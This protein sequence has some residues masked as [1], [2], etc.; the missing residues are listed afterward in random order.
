MICTMHY[1]EHSQ[2]VRANAIVLALF[3]MAKPF[4]TYDEQIEILK[5]RGLV[6]DDETSAKKFL[7]VDNYYSVING[8]KEPF[9]IS[10]SENYIPGAKFEY[11]KSL[12]LFDKELRHAILSTLLNIETMLKSIISY[13]IAKAY[14]ERSYLD[15]N[16]YNVYESKSKEKA[17]ELINALK[18]Q[19][20]ICET[21]PDISNENIRHYQANHGYVPIWV[22]CSHLKLGDVSKLYA[23]QK[24]QLKIAICKH[25]TSIYNKPITPNELYVF[26]RI[27]TNIRNLCAHNLRIYNYKTVYE[28]SQ[29]NSLMQK[30]QQN[31][32]T[33]LKYNNILSIVIIIY[34]LCDK[35]EFQRFIEGFLHELV[36]LIEL[37]SKFAVSLSQRQ[38]YSLYT[39]VDIIG[40]L[41]ETNDTKKAPASST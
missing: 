7:E 41:L 11:I 21:N 31:Y 4:K 22:L 5:S 24:P 9:I 19:I 14:G 17:K 38:N 13:E 30:L 37:P 36:D 23:C 27:L 18:E 25:I 1:M 6:F 32:G 40:M 26:L 33:N 3:I 16:T 39:F 15:I 2:N 28:L 20:K 29:K 34:S 12:Y 8:Y 10:G 35:D